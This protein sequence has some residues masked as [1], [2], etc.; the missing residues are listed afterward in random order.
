MFVRVCKLESVPAI[1]LE[2]S[3]VH[4]VLSGCECWWGW[5][6]ILQQP[7]TFPAQRG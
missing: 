6:C 2:P 4:R 5:Q 3:L 1:P 7:G